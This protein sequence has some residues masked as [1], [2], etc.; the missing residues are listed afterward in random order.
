[1]KQKEDHLIEERVESQ[2]CLSWLPPS[3]VP[4]APQAKKQSVMATVKV[5]AGQ[6]HPVG[7]TEWSGGFMRLTM[8]WT[9]IDRVGVGK[10]GEA[11]SV[12][13]A[14]TG[15][16]P[17]DGAQGRFWC[18]SHHLFKERWL[19]PQVISW[20]SEVS[21]SPN[22]ATPG[23]LAPVSPVSGGAGM[24]VRSSLTGMKFPGMKL[25]SSFPF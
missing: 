20:G 2:G 21:D 5:G 23:R 7:W 6:C 13:G 16:D 19:L 24:H 22:P 3:T 9:W 18:D 14:G 1:M 11:Y 4:V 17:M 25:L 12:V 8:N 10:G 15:R